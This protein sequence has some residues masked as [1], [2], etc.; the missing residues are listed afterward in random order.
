MNGLPAMFIEIGVA[1]RKCESFNFCPTQFCR[2]KVILPRPDLASRGFQPK[3]CWIGYRA[4]QSINLR[5][6]VNTSPQVLAIG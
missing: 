1:P 2:I 5:L 3:F 6:S 4:P